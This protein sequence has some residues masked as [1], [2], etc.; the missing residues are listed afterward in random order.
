MIFANRKVNTIC[1]FNRASSRIVVSTSETVI[2]ANIIT[3]ARKSINQF[4][5]GK[6]IQTKP[7]RRGEGKRATEIHV[8]KE[9]RNVSEI[10][11]NVYKYVYLSMES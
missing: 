5:K 6:W 3:R 7:A 2:D 1:R 10:N 4:I 11:E 9:E 8:R